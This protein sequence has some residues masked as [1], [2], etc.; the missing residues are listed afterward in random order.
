MI[1]DY[2]KRCLICGHESKDKKDFGYHLQFKHKIKI[3]D[4]IIKFYYNNKRPLCPI[5]NDE[6]RFDRKTT[7]FKK[8][9]IKHAKEAMKEGGKKGGKS[10]AWNKG[11]TKENNESLKK[12]SE[13]Y[14]GINHH[15]FGSKLSQSQ[16]DKMRKNKRISEKDFLAKL[17]LRKDDFICLTNYDK[18][19]SRQ[20]QYLDLICKKCGLEQ[21]KTLQ[22]LERGSLCRQCYPNTSSIHQIEIFKIINEELKLNAEISTRKII[23]PYELD[24]FIPSKNF[25]IE[26]NSLFYHKERKE[27]HNKTYHKMKSQLCDEKNIQLFH[28]FGDEWIDKKNIIISMLKNRLGF[29]EKKIGAR[30]TSV[31]LL[32]KKESNLFFDENHIDGTTRHKVAYG[33]IYKDQIVTAISLRIPILRKK[34]KNSIEIARF[35]SSQNHIILGGFSKLLKRVKQ[36]A[37]ENNCKSIITYAD[38]RFGK[39]KVYKKNNFTF[40]KDTGINYW[41][42]NDSKRFDRFKFRAKNGK[43]EKEIAEENKV[44][45]IYGCGNYLYELKI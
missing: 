2:Y 18:Y 34:Y 41:Y 16:I 12:Q 4:Y 17:D 13:T 8:Y 36:F 23:P 33:L 29:Y 31:K 42:T 5:C 3:E 44:Y 1:N 45:K 43:S 11:L 38:L 7:D 24:I 20:H 10:A 22:S 30:Q 25:A 19:Y 15:A 40:I 26:Y 39:G 14:R 32:S 27:G 9:C 21:N 6:T 37:K 35:A 28:I